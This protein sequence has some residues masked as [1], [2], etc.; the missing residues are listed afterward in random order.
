MS[1][2]KKIM[3]QRS[4]QRAFNSLL[5]DIANE[6]CLAEQFAQKLE[7]Y[8]KK[9]FD[10]NIGLQNKEDKSI[11]PILLY[12]LL[13]KR[14][15]LADEIL[16]YGADINALNCAPMLHGWESEIKYNSVLNEIVKNNLTH[17]V[18]GFQ[19]KYI[20]AIEWL[21]HHGAN[22]NCTNHR[23]YNLFTKN[24]CIKKDCEATAFAKL[25]S[26][27]TRTC[28]SK[29]SD[30]ISGLIDLFIE[31]GA[32]A[33]VGTYSSVVAE[34]LGNDKL[35]YTEKLQLMKQLEK[36]DVD[37]N[38]MNRHY[39]PLIFFT[40]NV[41]RFGR[42]NFSD[43]G[44]DEINNQDRAEYE[45]FELMLKAGADPNLASKGAGSTPL[46]ILCNQLCVPH[47]VFTDQKEQEKSRVLIDLIK[48][49][50]TYGANIEK[51]DVFGHTPLE[52]VKIPDRGETIRYL[53][54][55]AETI[56]E[57]DCI[58]DWNADHDKGCF[59]R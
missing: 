31:S 8:I 46:H 13:S 55:F 28:L 3:G 44:T 56:R 16:K 34:I 39:S 47:E 50:I 23:V 21:I 59:E 45:L 30:K 10:I 19:T 53:R 15:D 43:D 14:F 58:E 26:L 38:S 54:N 9:G 6:N 12:A 2:T 7:D 27:L 32:K 25:Y 41:M 57:Y 52:Y 29:Y 24:S 48:L 37:F 36:I 1:K 42:M 35:F 5:Q 4:T 18:K 22:V 20:T 51:T 40:K 11:G 17:H 33:Q 49:F